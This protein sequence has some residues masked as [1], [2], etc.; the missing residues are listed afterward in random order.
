MAVLATGTVTANMLPWRGARAEVTA[1][2]EVDNVVSALQTVGPPCRCDAPGTRQP[3]AGAEVAGRVGLG[4]DDVD[5][6]EIKVILIVSM[7]HEA[8]SVSNL[9]RWREALRIALSGLCLSTTSYIGSSTSQM[10]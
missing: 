2:H 5:G 9:A 6:G 4:S 1:E 3:A 10:A 7:L 8:G